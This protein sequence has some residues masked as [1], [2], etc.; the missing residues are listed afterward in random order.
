MK[1]IVVD[2]S[3]SP[4]ALLKPIPLTSV[5]LRDLFWAP[6][7][8]S[9]LSST[10]PAIYD[11]LDKTGPLDNFK[12]LIG[13][14]KAEFKG[15]Q[16]ADEHVYKWLEAAAWVLSYRHSEELMQ[17]VLEVVDLVEAV[18]EPDGYVNTRFF[19]KPGQRYRDLKWSHELYVGGHLIQAA[20]A[21]KRTNV[22]D[23]FFNI[24]LRYG[25]HLKNTFGPE[26]L[27]VSDGHPG[28]E[29]ALVELYRE[30][31]DKL[32]LELSN[33]FV[34]LRGYGKLDYSPYFIDN[35]PFKQLDEIPPGA[36]AV[37]F[38]YL[39]A[40]ATDIYIETGDKELYNVLK[41]L[42]L[43][44]VDRK[45]Y[46]TGGMGSRYAGEAFGAAYELPNE[47][48][49]SETCAAVA[50][51]MW[52]YRMLLATGDAKYADVMELTLYNAALAGISLD[53]KNFFYVNPLADRGGHRR[54]PWFDCPCC[55]PN[56]ARLIASIP[57]YFYSTSSDGIWVHLYA[58]SDAYIELFNNKTVHISQETEYPW[59]GRVTVKVDPE[60]EEEFALFLR[61]PGWA[62]NIKIRINKEPLDIIVKPPSYVRIERVWRRGD[63]VELNMDMTIDLLAADPRVI[64]DI[65]KVAIRR[66]PFVYCLEQTDNNGVDV[67][68]IG[69]TAKSNLEAK[70]IPDLLGGIV[71]IEGEGYELRGSNQKLYVELNQL[72]IKAKKIRFKAVPYYAWA[73]RE[74]GSMT[75][76]IP[77]IDIF[78]E[79]S[80]QYLNQ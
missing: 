27:E 41:R 17:K 11:Q 44:A 61:V 35:K 45:M 58:S 51:V 19:G 70:F 49:Y 26:K 28:I 74:P 43:D 7:I 34:E 50:N 78:K 56:I 59:D 76:W 22:C 16:F 68:S 20:I 4:Y 6:R 65:G 55:P 48:A 54:Q 9:L 73:N 79:G 31:G 21:C 42:W 52:N 46:V 53:G 10:L 18:Q 8:E 66:G 75:V 80:I 60:V 40:A 69:I 38:L 77:L 2:T 15:Y 62:K 36:H 67:W 64:A 39:A 5:K 32:Y 24:A 25:E 1:V 3:R 72:S 23:K 30:T 13:K 57:G 14:V 63:V 37:R 12:R 71:V 47:S 33:F 29:L